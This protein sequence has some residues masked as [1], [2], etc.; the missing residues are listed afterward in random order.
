MSYKVSLW[1]GY[2]AREEVKKNLFS[3]TLFLTVIYMNG[4][5]EPRFRIIFSVLLILFGLIRGYY[6]RRGQSSGIRVSMQERWDELVK[7]EGRTNVL[8][9][10]IGFLVLI[11]AVILYIA[12]P[13]WME[14]PTIPI[15]EWLRWLGVGLGAASLPLLIWVQHVLG[16]YF[17]YN[18][19][20]RE[21]HKLVTDGPYHWV[22]HPIYTVIII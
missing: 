20:L 21:N 7:Y 13:Q 11:I 3:I 17:S 15:P 10:V 1:V 5:D 19:E 8:L 14:W 12:H 16:K 9:R 22:R 4:S 2:K 6:A 18:L